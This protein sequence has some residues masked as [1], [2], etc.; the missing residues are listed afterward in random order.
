MS[1]GLDA[2]I[3]E[4][5]DGWYFGIEDPSV[6][7]LA[8]TEYIEEGPFATVALL[9]AAYRRH[10]NPGGHSVDL[11]T[12]DYDEFERQWNEASTALGGRYR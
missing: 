4:R 7:R 10:P 1:T 11:K 12:I 6:H 2:F 9:V 8:D 5:E 3:E